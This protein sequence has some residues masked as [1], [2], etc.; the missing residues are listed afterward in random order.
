MLYL[1][2]QMASMLRAQRRLRSL[3]AQL[4]SEAA[5]EWPEKNGSG[6]G[7][8]VGPNWR[9]STEDVVSLSP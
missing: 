1:V 6:P 4:C 5:V 8:Q 3:S 2:A 7:G 9:H